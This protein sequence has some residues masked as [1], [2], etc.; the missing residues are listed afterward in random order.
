MCTKK[1]KKDT[2]SIVQHTHWNNAKELR[3]KILMYYSNCV[4]NKT[5][6]IITFPTKRHENNSVVLLDCLR[7]CQNFN[8]CIP[9]LLYNILTDSHYVKRLCSLGFYGALEICILLLLLRPWPLFSLR[10]CRLDEP[11][12]DDR[13]HKTALNESWFRSGIVNR[14]CPM[15]TDGLVDYWSVGLAR[16]MIGTG[17]GSKAVRCPWFLFLTHSGTGS[18]RNR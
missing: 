7:L 18:Y 14:A 1:K 3:F 11:Q 8:P 13:M 17:G 4:L 12:S 10:P 2:Q 9:G 5:I 6:F 16:R 15:S